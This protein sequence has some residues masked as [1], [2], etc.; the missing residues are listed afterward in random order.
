MTH[1]QSPDIILILLDTLRVD[2][3][4]CYGYSRKTTPHIDTFAEQSTLFERAISPAQWTI[5]AHAS[6]FSGEYPSTHGTHQ[7]YDKH[8]KD[9]V[10]LA[11]YLQRAGYTT[12]G[13][14]NNPLLGVVENELDRGF[15]EFYNYGGVFPERPDISESR[16]RLWGQTFQRIGRRLN[17]LNQPIQD[18][19]TH[20]D[21][22]L[23]VMLHP[24]I[25]PFW[26]RY[27]NFKG[28]T[29][30]SIGDMVGYL[31]TRR[32]KEK[33]R[34]LFAFLNLMETH[35]PYGPPTR[36]IRKFAPYYH[37][38]RQ[39][40]NFMQSYNCETYRWI[41]PIT[42]AFTE[43]EDRV[44]NDMYDAEVAY[45]DHLLRQLLEYLEDP[46][47]LEQTMVIIMAD[48][49][50]GV[51]HHDY[52]GHSLVT[53]NDL[54]HVPLIIR[55]PPSYP[56]GKRI[57]S[58]VSSRRVFHTA[59]Q[60]AGIPPTTSSEQA[61]DEI[62]TLSLQNALNGA[63]PEQG[64]AFT[65]A[66]PPATLLALM[67]SRAP[68]DIATFRCRA[69]RRAIMAETLTKDYKLIT[70]DNQPEELFNIQSDPAETHNL[71]QQHPDISQTLNNTLQT[72]LSQAAARSSTH[73]TSQ[74]NLRDNQQVAERLR[75]LGY[76]E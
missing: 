65:E 52:V 4:S 24:L 32:R 37:Y 76:I 50:E 1:T 22:L 27:I 7:I 67:E 35:L 38:N 72:V 66:F 44:L 42:E 41:T 33:D 30:Q 21:F 13:F 43:L 75:G 48:H 23:G 11:E 68:E 46:E 64:I 40:R 69:T 28:N 6:I 56:A 14:C 36:F 54:V 26:Q 53:Y 34:P 74:L 58:P 25:V 59:L 62:N 31:K 60:A 39:A 49:G 19:V 47:I 16:P 55:Y 71:I 18:I 17:R 5:P 2:R 8:S 9:H 10:T 45:E 15:A 61:L 70:V 20:N 3:L 63:D 73:P 51:N 12:V 57:H 29:R